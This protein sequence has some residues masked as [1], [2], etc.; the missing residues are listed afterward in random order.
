MFGMP[1]YAG[2]GDF[3]G[4]LAEAMRQYR[5]G[6][7]QS[8][9]NIVK[10]IGEGMDAYETQQR[11]GYQSA[12]AFRTR[13]LASQE[14][15]MFP[16]DVAY[17]RAQT[18]AQEALEVDRLRSGELSGARAET[19]EALRDPTVR[20]WEE[21]P[22]TEQTR[23]ALNEARTRESESK[24]V[25]P[26]QLNA[27]VDNTPEL[28]EILGEKETYAESEIKLGL[29]IL[30]DQ[31]L[32]AKDKKYLDYYD[33][34]IKYTDKLGSLADVKAKNIREGKSASGTLLSPY[35]QMAQLKVDAV[36]DMVE[37]GTPLPQALNMVSKGLSPSAVQN[38]I[39]DTT[40]ILSD[41][42]LSDEEKA[43]AAETVEVLKKMRDSMIAPYKEQPQ[44][45]AGGTPVIDWDDWS[46]RSS[47]AKAK[48][49]I[50]QK[51][52][53]VKRVVIEKLGKPDSEYTL[54]PDGT[55][56]WQKV[57]QTQ[58]KQAQPQTK[59]QAPKQTT[60]PKTKKQAMQRPEQQLTDEQKRL[61]DIFAE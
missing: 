19:E 35:Q 40:K 14:A 61:L 16:E 51:N 25:T 13:Q 12:Q 1:N 33:A 11:A 58:A 27:V 42:M 26:A 9:Q 36:R 55:W 21:R 56:A 20:Y 8:A 60:T 49:L 15:R 17:K 59:A 30:R 2:I 45:Q 46:S 48:F 38:M 6:N 37:N 24:I 18:G 47:Q 22:K 43:D 50:E 3:V 23:Q 34:R 54:N 44:G 28:K 57:G 32:N 41:V 7:L 10:Q 5:E 53:G 29:K 52:Q 4:P 31:A 39:N